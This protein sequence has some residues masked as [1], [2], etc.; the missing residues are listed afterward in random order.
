VA[1]AEAYLDLVWIPCRCAW[2]PPGPGGE[3]PYCGRVATQLAQELPESDQPLSHSRTFAWL[4]ADQLQ[5]PEVQ[6]AR[7][8][9]VAFDPQHPCPSA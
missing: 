6:S 5:S 9:H 3:Y 7:A 1:G 8:A 2:K 4:Y